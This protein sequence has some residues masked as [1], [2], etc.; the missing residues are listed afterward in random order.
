MCIYYFAF[1][2]PNLQGRC[3]EVKCESAYFFIILSSQWV[4]KLFLFVSIICEK[5]DIC[6]ALICIFLT[7]SKAEVHFVYLRNTCLCFP[8]F[9]LFM[10]FV[11]LLIWFLFFS[12]FIFLY[13]E[14]ISKYSQYIKISHLS[15]ICYK[16][17]N[18]LLRSYNQLNYFCLWCHYSY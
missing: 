3:R 6:V 13:I 15:V 1:V 4:D 10:I 7:L 9:C 12:F 11:Y 5:N 18:I 16:I 17:A 2:E 14:N 8:K